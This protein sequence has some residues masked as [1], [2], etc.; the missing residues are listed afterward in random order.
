[1]T[2]IDAPLAAAAS[3]ALE[4]C[5]RRA[6]RSLHVSSLQAAGRPPRHWNVCPHHGGSRG[7]AA[8]QIGCCPVQQW[9]TGPRP[10]LLPGH[11][12]YCG[13]CISAIV[14]ADSCS[15]TTSLRR[16]DGIGRVRMVHGVM[17]YCYGSSSLS[18]QA[19][20]S[21][22]TAV[23]QSQPI[24]A[25][26]DHMTYISIH[27]PIKPS[28]NTHLPVQCLNTR[29]MLHMITSKLQSETKPCDK[30]V[31]KH[32]QPNPRTTPPARHSGHAWACTM[33]AQTKTFLVRESVISIY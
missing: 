1:M 7:H 25:S 33:P 17:L 11:S 30:S 6:S 9:P 18:W 26:C 20:S 4:R 10:Q 23:F 22:C 8:R 3:D 28:L 5:R 12:D 24:Q 19:I 2:T 32:H 31:E 13:D 29:S 27:A 14:T 16:K 21:H 15:T